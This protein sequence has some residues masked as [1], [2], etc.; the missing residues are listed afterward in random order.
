MLIKHIKAKN[1]K[2]YRNLDADIGIE[3]GM[4]AILIGKAN[5]DGKATLFQIAYGALY[6]LTIPNAEAFH[7]LLNASASDIGEKEIVLELH[8]SGKVSDN[9]HQYVLTRTYLL[10]SLQHPVES[11]QLH[12]NGT[13]LSYDTTMLPAQRAEEE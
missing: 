12:V 10:D 13:S 9:E 5:V 1:F 8:F 6:G 2:V 4:P 11:I 3:Q 7:E